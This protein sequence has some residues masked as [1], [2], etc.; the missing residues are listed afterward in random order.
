MMQKHKI[1]LLRHPLPTNKINDFIC[2]AFLKSTLNLNDYIK[3]SPCI[4][5]K[6]IARIRLTVLG[7]RISSRSIVRKAVPAFFRVKV[8]RFSLIA[9]SLSCHCIFLRPSSANSR[10]R[11][12]SVGKIY[13]IRI[14]HSTT[15]QI[16]SPIT[17][18]AASV[19]PYIGIC[20]STV[21][22]S[23]IHPVFHHRLPQF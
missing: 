15:I 1:H 23:M 6:N 12:F 14:V 7:F 18:I 5:Q 17:L 9:L 4:K 10:F 21:G 19:A 11:A 20:T 13:A 2:H 3:K 16:T 22:I 8:Q